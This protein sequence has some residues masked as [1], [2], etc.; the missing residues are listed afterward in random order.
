MCAKLAADEACRC[1]NQISPSPR[2]RKPG[3]AAGGSCGGTE[4][5]GATVGGGRGGVPHPGVVVGGG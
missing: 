4:R 3:R 2:G 1:T 5:D